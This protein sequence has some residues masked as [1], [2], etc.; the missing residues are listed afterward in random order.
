MMRVDREFKQ[1]GLAD[2]TLPMQ[3]TSLAKIKIRKSHLL[4]ARGDLRCCVS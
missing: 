2:A 4:V 1:P 3:I